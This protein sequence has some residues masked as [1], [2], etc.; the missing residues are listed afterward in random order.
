ML[1]EFFAAR[2]FSV[3]LRSPQPHKAGGTAGWFYVVAWRFGRR[4]H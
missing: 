2:T 4:Q 1:T 3:I